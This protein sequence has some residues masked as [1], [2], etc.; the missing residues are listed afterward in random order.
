MTRPATLVRLPATDST[1]LKIRSRQDGTRSRILSRSASLFVT[2]G[3]E[4]V[5]VEQIILAAGIARSSFYRFFANREEV[6]SAIIRPVFE[7]G[8]AR[9]SAITSQDARGVVHGILDTYLALWAASPD[10]LRLSIRTGG[11]HFE[12]FRDLHTPF[13]ERITTLLRLIE[14]GGQLLNKS[15]N[16][17]ASLIAR[18]AVP[19]LE[20]Y[21]RDSRFSFLFHS[22]MSGLLL[23]PA[24]ELTTREVTA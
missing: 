18:T 17:T 2:Q 12:L 11:V 22:T 15:S 23:L 4:N 1:S 21:Q 19:V 8:L 9:L 20:I 16:Y 24:H 14:P 6:L 7:A 10:A 3:Y 5:S 13:R